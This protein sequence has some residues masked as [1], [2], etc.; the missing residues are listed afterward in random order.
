[1]VL[2]AAICSKSGVPLF[3][4]QF[5]G[6]SKARLESLLSTFPQLIKTGQQHTYVES[7]SVRFV[8]QPLDS[9]YLIIITNV[10][11]NILQDMD[12]LQMLSKAL[13]DQ[14]SASGLDETL[15]ADKTFD[16]ILAFDEIVCL[17]YR[18]N[19]S[20]S[21]LRTVLAMESHEEMV[22]EI[23]ARVGKYA[24]IIVFIGCRIKF[25]RPKKLQNSR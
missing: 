2:A 5:L 19:V 24:F 8:Y 9:Y 18:Q 1:M 12:T 21:S 23:I 17:G 20:A 15:I 6:L 22:Q 3:S 4:R 11:S 7:D 10:L 13:N 14:S 25:K 16:I